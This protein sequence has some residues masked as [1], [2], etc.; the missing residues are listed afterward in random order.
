MI[1]NACPVCKSLHMGDKMKRRAFTLIELLVVISIIAMLMAIM[2]PAL[3]KARAQ[4]RKSICKTNMHQIGIAIGMYE[5]AFN[6]DIKRYAT[7]ANVN[8]DAVQLARRW[9]WTNGTGDYAHEP[10]PFSVTYIMENNLLPDYKVFFCPGI[11]N[12]SYE[13]NYVLSDV[14]AG[15]YHN[16]IETGEIYRMI[17]NAKLSSTDRPL[18]WSTH[19]W[20]WRKEIR[21]QITSVNNR[22]K[23]AM[24]CDMTNGAW[25]FASATY[26][27]L[28]SLI[29]TAGIRR[30]NQHQN[31]DLSVQN[32]SDKD[33]DIVQWLWDSERWAGTGY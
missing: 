14:V 2:M 18:F 25:E 26:P 22:S 24:M 5:T 12:L 16:P 20:L 19:I 15:D 10:S 17:K 30:V 29:D 21:A 8:N 13:Q 28:G 11:S 9:A 1:V 33:E 32:P 7:A 31:V 23:D 6:F 4:A 27:A 3:G